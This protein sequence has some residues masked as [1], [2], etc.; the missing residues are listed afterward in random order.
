[1]DDPE[2]ALVICIECPILFNQEGVLEFIPN[3]NDMISSYPD[4]KNFSKI[5][6]LARKEG[7]LL[8]KIF[9][10]PN[11]AYLLAAN[12]HLH[13]VSPLKNKNSQ[14]I[15]VNLAFNTKIKDSQ[16]YGKTANKLYA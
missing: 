7:R 3:F 4:E 11:Q 14:R 12:T 9:S 1:M 2:L 15:V 5:A 13:R 6:E 8:K 16:S 10:R